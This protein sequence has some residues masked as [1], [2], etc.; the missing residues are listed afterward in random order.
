VPRPAL[1]TIVALGTIG[2]V[3]LPEVTPADRL[4]TFLAALTAVAVAPLIHELG[5]V[6]GGRLAGFRFLGLVWSPLQLRREAGHL[7]LSANRRLALAGGL[8]LCVPVDPGHDARRSIAGYVAGGPLLSLLTGAG[9][10]RL[11]RDLGMPAHGT[12]AGWAAVAFGLASLRMGL[13][14]LIPMRR[15]DFFRDGARRIRALRSPALARLDLACASLIGLALGPIRPR[16]WPAR[17]IDPILL[18]PPRSGDAMRF[19]LGSLLCAR[20]WGSVRGACAAASGLGCGRGA[21]VA[22]RRFRAR[23]GLLRTRRPP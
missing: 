23:G 18:N 2:R 10:L 11:A 8:T 22:R 7:R 21:G 13:V 9:A 4:A 15:G 3:A 12:I 16:E 19:F 14:A 6:V 20:C 1:V 5:H 17:L